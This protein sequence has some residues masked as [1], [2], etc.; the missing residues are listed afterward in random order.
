MKAPVPEEE[1]GVSTGGETP[2]RPS[3]S[4][5]PATPEKKRKFP[6]HLVETYDI[7]ALLGQGS[8]SKVWRCVHRATGQ[9]RAIKRIDISD[10]SPREIAHEVNM[11]KLLRHENILTCYD[12]FLEA[13]YVNIVVDMFTGGDLID[14]LT[15]HSRARG[16]IP[17]AQ[18]AHL[19]RQMMA[20]IAHVHSFDIVHR[21]VKGENFLSDRPDIGDPEC[22]VALA[23]FGTA[24]RLDHGQLLSDRV[25]T[26]AFWAPEV[27]A[28]EYGTL[29][30]VWAVGVTA[31]VLLSNA[32]PFSNEEETC[33]TIGVGES[34]CKIPYFAT[35]P[36]RD[37]IVECLAKDPDR[38]PKAAEALKLRWMDTPRPSKRNGSRVAAVV[39][40]V[41]EVTSI[42]GDCMGCILFGVRGAVV[43][44]FDC[45]HEICTELNQESASKPSGKQELKGG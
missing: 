17:D 6:K 31:M 15:V 11:M 35:R 2:S 1:D 39:H 32:L 44:L 43:G 12:V 29:V 41:S 25:G 10:F 37:F 28:G 22:R 34:P 38:R 19:T 3:R 20:A 16:R 30:D 7:E 8:F 27:W 24:A 45:V 18:L 36:C 9:V 14:G 13:Q 40:A 5:Q 4:E 26:P 42:V 33:A 23:D 21:D